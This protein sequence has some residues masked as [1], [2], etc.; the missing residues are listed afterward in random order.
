MFAVLKRDTT[1]MVVQKATELGVSALL[2]VFTERTDRGAGQSRPAARHHDR[3][4]GAKRA[5]DGSGGAHPAL[6]LPE[7]LDAWPG[8]RPLYVALERTC[9]Q[10]SPER[11]CRSG[12]TADRPRRRSGTK[13]PGRAG[14][15]RSLFTRFASV[16]AS[17]GRRQPRLSVSPCCKHRAVASTMALTAMRAG[18][19]VFGQSACAI[20]GSAWGVPPAG[21]GGIN[22]N[23]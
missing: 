20:A 15:A 13:G 10:G 14:S 12:R 2:P 17:C 22:R 8:N 19:P 21:A 4:G 23:V 5:V 3:G 9:R 7:A 6:P 18:V 1:D 16:R 11:G